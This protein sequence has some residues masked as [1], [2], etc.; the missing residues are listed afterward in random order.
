MV[1]DRP[2]TSN[3]AE[4][5][6]GRQP[7]LDRQ[8]ALFGYELLFRS[9][10]ENHADVTNPSGATADVVCKAFSELGLADALGTNRAFINVDC[11]L[12][13]SDAIEL[14]PPS[15]VV[16]EISAA[17]I[18]D[19]VVYTRCCAL[20][21]KGYEVS[22]AGLEL[23]MNALPR[24]GE[25]ATYVK[26]DIDAILETEL[27]ST[28]S[29]AKGNTWKLIASRV[30]SLEAMQRCM[31]LGFDY[32]QG[33]YFAHPI[34]LEGRKLDTSTQGLMQLIN[35]IHTDAEAGKLEAAFKPEPGLT[36]NVWI[37]VDPVGIGI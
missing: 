8:Q 28:V 26:I 6:L 10:H 2:S 29:Q 7:I 27:A 17:E 33:Y 21:S 4:T 20:K 23:A 31:T 34:I 14:L 19:E 3:A 36:I 22:V 30:E 32:F 9:S 37:L 5:F 1:A 12:L 35:L 25:I 15:V 24:L 18:L 13:A 16:L 11:D